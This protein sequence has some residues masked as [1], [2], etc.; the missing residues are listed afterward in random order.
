MVSCQ[1]RVSCPQGLGVLAPDTNRT[2]SE[3]VRAHQDT[4]KQERTRG[5]ARPAGNTPS[6]P[7]GASWEL[8][9]ACGKPQ[10]QRVPPPAPAACQEGSQKRH[11]QVTP[12]QHPLPLPPQSQ[13]GLFPGGRQRGVKHFHPLTSAVCCLLNSTERRQERG[14]P[15]THAAKP[16]FFF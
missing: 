9:G 1:G 10:R 6:P 2:H 15:V 7:L 3:G 12:P 14:A 16:F 8:P 13:A 5:Q 4:K 11:S